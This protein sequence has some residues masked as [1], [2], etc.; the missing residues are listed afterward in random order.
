MR[1]TLDDAIS[2]GL[3]FVSLNNRGETY[4]ILIS[5]DFKKLYGYVG[6]G[7]ARKEREDVD[8]SFLPEDLD[9]VW[10]SASLNEYGP[11][12]YDL[13]LSETTLKGRDLCCGYHCSPSARNIWNFYHFKRTPEMLIQRFDTRQGN[14]DRS[15]VPYNHC[16]K[17]QIILDASAL[18]SGHKTFEET[19]MLRKVHKFFSR[20]FHKPQ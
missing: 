15:F 3:K 9:S 11:L 2:E 12:V 10:Y 14:Q 7:S 5:G 16:Y 18:K 19:K 17:L 20:E 6:T 13:A 1:K 8:L 4:H